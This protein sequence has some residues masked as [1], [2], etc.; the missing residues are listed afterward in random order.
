MNFGDGFQAGIDVQRAVAAVIHVVAAI[1][2]PVVV[3][4][5]AAIDAEGHAAVDADRAFVLTGLIADARDQGDQLGK[6]APVQLQLGD[7]FSANRT[8]KIRRLRLHL[9]D[10]RTFYRHLV[11]VAPTCRATSA[12][13]FWPTGRT[14][15]LASYFLKPCAITVTL[16]GPEGKPATR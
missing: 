6:V 15:P 9:G 11:L 5:A 12:R 3:L 13:A 16:I 1:E 8:G 4:G 2:F 10:V 7:L 14:T